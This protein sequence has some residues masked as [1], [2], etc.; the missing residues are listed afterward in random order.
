MSK[1]TKSNDRVLKNKND[2]RPSAHVRKMP[3]SV[4]IDSNK[5]ETLHSNV[6]ELVLWI[7]DSGCSNHMTGNLQLLRNFVEKFMGT[8]RFKNDHFI[9]IT[10]YGDYVQGNLTICHVYY[11]EGLGHN[12]FQ[13]VQ[14][15][16]DANTLVM[17]IT[18]Y[19]SQLLLKRDEAPQINTL[20]ILKD[21]CVLCNAPPTPMFE[22][23]KSS[24]TY[25]DPSNMHKFHQKHSSSDKWT[26][27][28]PIEQVIGDL[29]KPEA[30]L[31]ASWIESMQDEL[32]QFKCFA[33]WELVELAKGYCQDEGINFEESLASVAR[34]EVVRSFSGICGSQELSYLPNG[35]QNGISK[36]HLDE[37]A[38]ARLWISVQQD[39]NEH[40]EKSTIELYFLG[41][42]CQ[43]ADLFTKSLPKERFKFTGLKE[44]I[45][46]PEFIKLMIIDLM[47]KFPNISQ[48]IN[49]DYHY[50]KDDIPLVSVYTTGN[51][52]VV[53]GEKDDDDSEDRLKPRSHKEN[54]EYVDDDDDDDEEKVD[55]TKD[56][57]MGSLETRTKEMQTP[58]PTPPRSP[59]TILSSNKNITQELTDTIPLPT[60]TTSKAPHSK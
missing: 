34:L 10:G 47:K 50:I 39:S 13:S 59:R 33:V 6:I 38:T 21:K 9:E 36:R 53:E 5:R 31:D 3:S 41:T 44:A 57:E 2:K 26:K 16:S 60:T 23:V 48:R 54:P 43:L 19:L 37:D 29:S 8:V 22:E 35:R 52:L 55:E 45:H 40:V 32:D 51:V 12:L 56:V 18:S 28:H 30:M 14:D 7:I 27:N 42:K 11:V 15:H 24:S 49:E 20:L 46:Y 4:S 17:A 1:D 58:I 25:H